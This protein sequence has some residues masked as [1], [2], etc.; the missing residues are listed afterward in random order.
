MYVPQNLEIFA[1]LGQPTQKVIPVQSFPSPSSSPLILLCVSV[2]LDA[3]RVSTIGYRQGAIVRERAMAVDCICPVGRKGKMVVVV[4]RRVPD[5]SCGGER[6][7]ESA[8]LHFPIRQPYKAP[9]RSATDSCL[10]LCPHRLRPR[11]RSRSFTVG[12]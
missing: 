1:I 10:S 6:A 7:Y 8:K 11:V 3:R 5:E 2:N 4:G 9:I 12:D